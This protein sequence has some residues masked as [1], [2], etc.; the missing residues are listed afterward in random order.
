MFLAR[1]IALPAI[2]RIIDRQ[3]GFEQRLVV[4]HKIAEAERDGIEPWRLRS[5]VEPRG[6]GAAHDAGK[7]VQRL[8]LQSEIGD[9]GV[10]TTS[11]TTVRQSHA[12]DTEGNGVASRR[13][14]NYASRRY[15]VDDRHWIDEAPDEPGAGNAVD[16]R[17]R[18][19]YPGGR[20]AAIVDLR[21]SKMRIASFDPSF[22]AAAE[23]ACIN[24]GGPQRGCRRLPDL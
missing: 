16:L 1:E 24:A 19:R 6:I 4:G 20:S 5:Q 23:I 2:E 18:S 7:P 21:L 3:A 10:E 12:R 22:D 9:H 14:L 11:L 13:F 15:V 17:P 8:V